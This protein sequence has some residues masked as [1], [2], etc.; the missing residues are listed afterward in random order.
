[1]SILNRIKQ[2]DP[3]IVNSVVLLAII[4]S[5]LS[6]L[7]L[8][9]KVSAMTRTL[10]DR[11]EALPAG[12]LVAFV[13]DIEPGLGDEYGPCAGAVFTHVM[14]RP[15]KVVIMCFY[16][17]SPMM[18]ERAL[19]LGWAEV[20]ADKKYGTD[21]V[22]LGYLAGAETAMASAASDLH[23]AFGKDFFGTPIA[24]IPVMKEALTAKDFKILI[25]VTGSTTGSE[26][27]LRQWQTTY[28]IPMAW[29]VTAAQA[30][31]QMPYYPRQV[32]AILP[33]IRSA[34]EYELLI[35]RPRVGL[36]NTDALSIV[37]TLILGF[38]VVANIAYFS[39][40]R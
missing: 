10:Y 1:M 9:V 11:I 14:R 15:L 6:P 38:I 23:K 4:F 16:Q 24:Q 39:K 17:H 3:A 25:H 5:L 8:P 34:A 18:W 13:A 27:M 22:N 31:S 20:P 30:P 28:G 37:Q 35:R 19:R 32:L 12:S 33:G 36:Q 7:G 29:I 40:K 2:L 26:Q 21:Y